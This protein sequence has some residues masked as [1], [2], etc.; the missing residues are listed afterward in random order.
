MVERERGTPPHPLSILHALRGRGR[1]HETSYRLYDQ[2]DRDLGIG[3]GGVVWA[4]DPRYAQSRANLM[5]GM[6]TRLT[7]RL[8]A[9]FGY[10]TQPDGVT[11]GLSLRLPRW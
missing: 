3:F 1:T 2:I 8:S 10:E 7:S 5:V 9:H 11:A 6:I 4:K